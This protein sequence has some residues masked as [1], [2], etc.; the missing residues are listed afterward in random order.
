M[1]LF[2]SFKYWIRHKKRAFSIVFAVA[3]SMAALT[4]AA[5]LARSSSVANLESQLDISGNYDVLLPDVSQDMLA[6]YQKDERFSASGVLYRGGSVFSSNGMEFCYGSLDE[7]AIDLYHST[8]AEGRYPQKSGEITA[9]R[10]FF[11]ADGCYPKIGASLPLSLYD[12]DGNLCKEG[13]FTI[14][15]ILDDRNSR[16]LTGKDGYVFPN[17]FVHQSDIPQGDGGIDLLA[18][19]EFSTDIAK[20]KEEFSQRGVEFYDGSRIMMMNAAA[21]V[22][23][24]EISEKALYNALGSAH[25][26]F[27]AYAL[28]P[29]FSF[30]V[31]FAAFVSICNVVASSLSE[32]KRQMAM[33]R[34]I[35]MSK[36]SVFQMAF[37]EAACMIFAGMAVGFVIGMAFYL[38]ILNV[39]GTVL[40]LQVYPAFFVN[41]VIAATTVNPYLFPAAA[42]F[43][44]S[45]LAILLPYVVF[46][47]KSSI[48]GLHEGHAAVWRR[49]TGRKHK[50]AL[51]GK[52]SGGLAQN[53]S[54]F[55]IVVVIVW[56]SVFGYTYFLAQSAVDNQHYEK[57]LEDTR[58]M[59]FDYFAER[60][61][62]TAVCGSAQLNRHSSGITPQLAGEIA[63]SDC[64]EQFLSCIEAKSTKAVFNQKEIDDKTLAALSPVSL[65]HQVQKGLEEL[66]EKSL[67]VQGYQDDE[68]LFNIPTIGA[69][70]SDLERLSEYLTDGEAGLEKLGSGEEVW[71]LRTTGTDPFALGQKLSM[72]DVVIEDPTVEAYDFSSGY[73]PE[74]YEPHFYYD[75][76]EYENMKHQ[77]GYA[78]GKRCDYEVTVGGHLDITDE[79]LAAFFQTNGLA[80]DCGFLILCSENALA[81]WGLPDRNKTKLGVVIKEDA[82]ITDF[83]QL[84]YRMIG[85]S[86]EV[87]CQSQSAIIRQMHDVEA[88]NMSIFFSIIIIVVIL[89]LVGM[90][91]SINLRVRRKLYSYSVLRA[92]GL[93]KA[94]LILVILRQGI[95]Y[96][97]IGAM[98][99]ILPL[100]VFEWF[101][102]RAD[103]YNNTGAAAMLLSE[104]GRYNIPWQRLFPTRVEL[105]AQPLIPIVLTAFLFV[106][107]IMLVSNVLPAVWVTKKNI[108]DALRNDDF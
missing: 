53:I 8:P 13:T 49:R 20:L 42:C 30:I 59:G 66:H 88:M 76:T 100:V 70:D 2:L 90:I 21:L 38:L 50:S 51:F 18:D 32:R 67:A 97:L 63:A 22:P 79:K 35:G 4:C 29:V 87:S 58:L 107:L 54:L 28:I 3:V 36:G 82:S 12:R 47:H 6:R 39:Q 15:G 11:E 78:F 26:D 60:N 92:I 101:R 17:V 89:G 80:G 48:E 57:L 96:V 68:L 91:D 40:G 72:T 105:F 31:L 71:I 62:D 16:Q 1:K 43:A 86:K 34:C 73:I 41:P 55:L 56:S 45:L 37:T 93:S 19:Y 103:A 23:I 75:D 84:W 98:T 106:C 81:K 25:K 52:L 9:C 65:D 64:V 69:A 85:N 44:C 102:K 74:G 33:L 5:F 99:S 94:G 14:V 108:T 83:E 95:S 46:L 77:P 7:S 10:S 104:N 27:Y 24:T 61:F